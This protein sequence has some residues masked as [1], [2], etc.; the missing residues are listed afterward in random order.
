MEFFSV[1]FMEDITHEC[2]VRVCSQNIVR[3]HKKT[4]IPKKKA[5]GNMV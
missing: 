3:I 4:S 1:E 5:L 2:S